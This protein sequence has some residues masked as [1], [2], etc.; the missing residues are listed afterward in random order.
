MMKYSQEETE[1]VAARINKTGCLEDLN[2]LIERDGCTDVMPVFTKNEIVLNTDCVERVIAIEEN[3]NMNKS[4]DCIFV[5]TDDNNLESVLAEFKFNYE[6]VRNL[7]S[8]KL[9]EKVKGT[10]INLKIDS[11]HIH[12]NYFF[13][14]DSNMKEQARNKFRRFNPRLDSNF[15]FTDLAGLTIF[16]K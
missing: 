7:K 8:S 6:G 12:D 15:I 2:I 14:F 3:R 10:S 16:F 11:L 9:I 5:I 4:M 13:V 1:K